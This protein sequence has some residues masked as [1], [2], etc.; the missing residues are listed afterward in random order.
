MQMIA[1]FAPNR[2]RH[3]FKEVFFWK[4]SVNTA[5]GIVRAVR[6]PFILGWPAGALIT[7]GRNFSGRSV[8]LRIDAVE[9]GEMDTPAI[10][11]TVV[12]SHNVNRDSFRH[13]VVHRIRGNSIRE[14]AACS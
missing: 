9:F 13:Q 7:T 10:A 8:A 5:P 1:A 12:V 3:E 4:F 11:I 2:S 14:N 6:S